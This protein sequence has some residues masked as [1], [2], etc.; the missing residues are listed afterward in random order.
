[1]ARAQGGR[2]LLQQLRELRQ[3]CS[4]GSSGYA[5]S[6]GSYASY[7][8]YSSCGSCG[9]V[10][11]GGMIM[12]GGMQQGGTMGNQPPAPPTPAEMNGTAP[13]GGATPGA[14]GAPPT[15]QPGLGTPGAPA[16]GGNPT[17]SLDEA[18]IWANLPADAK[19]L[20]NGASTKSL[21]AERHYVSRGL[22]QGRTYSYKLRVEFQRDGQPV[23]EDKIVQLHAGDSVQVAFGNG[24]PAAEQQTA[25][26]ELKLHV[27]EQA[28]VT[29]AGAATKQTGEVR[30]YTT[31]GLNP[32]QHWDGYTVR[33]ELEKD[34]KTVVEEKT[35]SIEGG[36]SY[37][38]S[39]D[40]NGDSVKVASAN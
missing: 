35:L 23:V 30:S 1:L 27:P 19:V 38:L 31:A 5:V 8:S 15:P 40:M 21:G 26:T 4:S 2:G 16:A 36:K 34:G 13:Q 11:D 10:Y 9:S 18:T 12:D 3:L 7:G 37:E 17:T 25:K 28:K 14:P 6:Y 29:L 20:V 39:F 33:V 22:E 24:Q 32:G